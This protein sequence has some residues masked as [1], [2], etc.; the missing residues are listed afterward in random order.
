MNYDDIISSALS[1][2][3]RDVNSEAASKVSDFISVLEAKLNRRLKVSQM[4]KRSVTT[5]VAGQEYYSL[6]TDFAG[7]RDI[8]IKDEINSTEK[9]TL[10][11]LPP[12]RSNEYS[13]RTLSSNQTFY[14][15]IANQIQIIPA[16]SNKIMEVV[17]YQRI[18]SLTPANTSNWLSDTYPDIYIFGLMTE[19]S[20][21]V[22]DAEAAGLWGARFEEAISELKG[23]DKNS[24]WS[25][26]T[27]AI[28]REV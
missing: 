5:T 3:D 8:E 1:Y 6:P 18:P 27:M 22:K 4:A 21:F 14:T 25:G 10:T 16:R 17:Y 12:E 7:L 11:F 24:R 15:I 9:Q 13:G 20:A 19:I 2:S 28:T 26:A 23:D